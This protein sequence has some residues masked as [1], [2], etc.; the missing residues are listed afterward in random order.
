ML[1][2]KNGTVKIEGIL[3]EIIQDA[4]YIL[5]GVYSEFIKKYGEETANEYFA[6]IGRIATVTNIEERDSQIKVFVCE[7]LETMTNDAPPHIKPV[8]NAIFDKIKEGEK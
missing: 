8:M 4:I 5:S 2:T 7:I 1:L 3:L 6:R